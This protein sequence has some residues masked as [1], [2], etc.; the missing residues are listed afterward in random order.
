LSFKFRMLA[1]RY[2]FFLLLKCLI[3]SSLTVFRLSIFLCFG[4]C[5]H[6]N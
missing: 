2:S 4:S 6:C 1:F 5:N 3:A